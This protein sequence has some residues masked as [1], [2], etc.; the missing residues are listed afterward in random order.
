MERYMISEKK[1]AKTERQEVEEKK[2]TTGEDKKLE[3]SR[4]K[5]EFKIPRA[6]RE[7]GVLLH[8]SSLPGP[9]G[10]GTLGKEAYK[11]IDFLKESGQTYWQMLPIGPTGFG[12]SPYQSFSTFAGNPYFID[13]DIL[14]EEG[15]LKQEEL[16]DL[17]KIEDPGKVDYGFQYE[18]RIPILKKA[19][20]RFQGDEEFYRFCDDNSD[21]LEDYALFMAI[22]DSRKGDPWSKW[23]KPLK[24][25][26]ERALFEFRQTHVLELEYYKFLQFKFFQQWF[27]LREYA[28]KQGIKL[29]GDLPIY[30]AQDSAD[31]WANPQIFLFD[32]NRDP[33][34]VGGC[35]PD[36]FTAEGQLWG[37]PIYDWRALEETGYEWWIERFRFA[38]SMFDTLRIDHFRGFESFWAVPAE[39]ET[40]KR[41]SWQQGPG[42]AL[43]KKMEEELGKQDIIAEDLGYMTRE[44]YELR[45]A[46]GYPGMKILQFAFE[47]QGDS[48][49]LPHNIEE[50]SVV[51]TGTHDNE[52]IIGWL[53]NVSEEELDFAR[54]YFNLTHEETYN[55]GMIRG[56]WT[57][58]AKI[59]ICTMQDLLFLDNRCRMNTP[60][61][62][63][64]N[65][66]WR[67]RPEADLGPVGQYLKSLTKISGRLPKEKK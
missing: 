36:A 19:Y 47:N 58:R 43:F 12:D 23:P 11:I 60:G 10:I 24:L 29:I 30:V 20:V 38:F 7:S 42:I 46:T 4:E 41:G 33:I 26:E 44:V 28:K 16:R 17:S 1:T 9:Y 14:V 18:K 66:T 13:L 50:N 54:R 39:S 51:Y 8:I 52:T 27:A 3:V 56:A 34:V 53:Q 25:R 55:W 6:K 35:P 37:N 22:K 32:E 59:A 49:Y 45:Q 57:S 40:A 61:K 21:W 62:Q 15:L 63:S 64:G 67:I 48:D 2:K 5:K 65:W 31:A